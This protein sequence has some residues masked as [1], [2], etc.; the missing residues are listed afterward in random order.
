[1]YH[2]QSI[3]AIAQ[4]VEHLVYTRA[5][6]FQGN[7]SYNPITKIVILIDALPHNFGRTI[8]WQRVRSD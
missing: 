7:P 1:M 5:N 4:L 2:K 8:A 6:V 3:R